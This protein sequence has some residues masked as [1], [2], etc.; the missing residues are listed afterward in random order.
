MFWL[1]WWVLG[2][3][4]VQEQRDLHLRAMLRHSLLKDNNFIAS[5]RQFSSNSWI[6]IQ[7]CK[8]HANMKGSSK[9]GVVKTRTSYFVFGIAT[10]ACIYS[11]QEYKTTCVRLE[12][13]IVLKISLPIDGCRIPNIQARKLSNLLTALFC[14][15]L[16]RWW[17]RLSL[18]LI[19][20]E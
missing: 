9:E 15:Q 7:V 17:K 11:N 6:M 5:K 19:P 10:A 14:I 13:F 16:L 12:N 18:I 2:I 4:T 3:D 1:Y 8:L 20:H